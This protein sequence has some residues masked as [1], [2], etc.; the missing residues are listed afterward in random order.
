M[1]QR[2][3]W[4]EPPEGLKFME[5]T[6]GGSP[7]HELTPLEEPEWVRAGEATHMRPGDP[8]I[9]VTPADH[10]YVLPWWVMKNHHVAN[11]LLDGRPV[12]VILCERCSSAMAFDARVGGERLTFQVMG[13]WKGTH[14]VA[15]HQTESIW[16]SFTGEC[17][18]GVHHGSRL[19]YLPVL[20]VAW[21]EWVAADPQSLVA[22]GAGESRDGHGSN[23]WP[24]SRETPLGNFSDLD[25]RLPSNELVLGV[26]AGGEAR[27]YWLEAVER[28]GGVVNDALGGVD[29]AVFGGRSGYTAI[30]FERRLGDRVLEFVRRDD[31]IV[32]DSSGSVWDVTGRAVSGP[33]AGQRLAHVRSLVEEWYAW[34]AYHP[35][36]EL[37]DEASLLS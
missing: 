2:A 27:A 13:V 36:T 21:E 15:D 10:S 20:Q 3:R 26:E 24:G 23:R 29:I 34:A 17:V 8:V 28:S 9:V 37:Y 33:L 14:V 4:L 32:D 35:H 6:S 16:T 18:W 30:A 1:T 7:R 12:S 22:D 19:E 5:V 11:L 31:A 25:P